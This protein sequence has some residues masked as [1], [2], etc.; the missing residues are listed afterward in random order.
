[1]NAWMGKED[2]ISLCIYYDLYGLNTA[3]FKCH[4]CAEKKIDNGHVSQ[5]K[6]PNLAQVDNA[7]LKLPKNSDLTQKRNFIPDS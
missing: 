7:R 2:I 1:L 4:F 3:Q 5:T 6:N